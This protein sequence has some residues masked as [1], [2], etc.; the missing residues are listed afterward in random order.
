MV[1][2]EH[3]LQDDADDEPGGLVPK[4][5]QLTQ[6]ADPTC[7]VYVP[8]LHSVHP[9]LLFSFGP[10]LPGSH[11]VQ[12]LDPADVAYLPEAQAVQELDPADAACFPEAQA[13]H[14]VE[15]ADVAYL[16]TAHGKHWL[17]DMWADAETTAVSDK[18]V[19]T[20]HASQPNP[21]E[22]KYPFGQMTHVFDE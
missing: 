19:P 18:Y 16:P 9:L 5:P 22:E 2:V 10:Y 21:A 6:S 11:S 4:A 20:G 17:D 14:A 12:E 7:S 15:P 8:A 3:T 13:I 1:T